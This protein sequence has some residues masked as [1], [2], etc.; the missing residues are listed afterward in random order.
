MK[1]ELPQSMQKT[2]DKAMTG[3]S[4]PAGVK[5]FCCECCGYDRSEV[6]LCTDHTCP[7]YPYRPF[8]SAVAVRKARELD[9]AKKASMADGG[10][11]EGGQK[12]P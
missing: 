4:R 7:L 5:A 8:R 9:A 1:R 10:P 12:R 11:R 6:S 2:Y 3:R